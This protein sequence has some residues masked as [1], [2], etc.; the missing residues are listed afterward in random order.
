[1][2]TPKKKPVR[3]KSPHAD[4]KAPST[5][6]SFV[7]V[8]Q[9]SLFG[10]LFGMIAAVI[11]LFAVTAIGY[12]TPDPCSLTTPLALAAHYLS[13][14][15]AGFAAIRRQRSTALLCGSLGGLFLMLVFLVLSL[16]LKGQA[17]GGFYGISSLLLRLFM[18]PS[19]AI[20]AFLGL[21]RSTK[22]RPRTR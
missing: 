8:C 11:L 15:V 10:A 17:D 22:K 13:S 9:S 20:G 6:H 5:D 21:P 18:L 1:M 3:K 4:G 12:A 14:V 16:L 7:S 2:S 19:A